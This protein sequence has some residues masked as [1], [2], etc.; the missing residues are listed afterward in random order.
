MKEGIVGRQV[1][2]DKSYTFI[3]GIFIGRGWQSSLRAL[4]YMRECHKMKDRDG[5]QPYWVHPLMMASR[6]I[7]IADPIITDYT[8]SVILLHD[9][10]EELGRPAKELPFPEK[11]CYGVDCMTL[12]Y[13]GN[14]TLAQKYLVKQMYYSKMLTSL[15]AVIAKGFDKYDNL[16]TMSPEQ[17]PSFT[18]DRIRKNVV[19]AEILTLMTLK[20]AKAIWPEA[21]NVIYLLQDMIRS[22]NDDLALRYGVKLR[23][24]NFINPPTAKDYS[25]LL[26]GENAPME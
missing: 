5:G 10:P 20:K 23:D 1:N 19:E 25:Y 2:I 16:I 26:T 12:V 7:S 4:S 15:E 6:A 24:K 17:S 3:K 18:P 14:E 11:V 21:S 8:M 13:E 9:V 22:R